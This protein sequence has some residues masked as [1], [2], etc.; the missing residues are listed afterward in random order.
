MASGA[1]VRLRVVGSEEE[2]E[3]RG[4]PFLFPYSHSCLSSLSS[5]VLLLAVD[6]TN[7]ELSL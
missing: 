6:G 5:V 7:L 1:A 2:V 4:V 3:L